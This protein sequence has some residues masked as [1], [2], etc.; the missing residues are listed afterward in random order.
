MRFCVKNKFSRNE[1]VLLISRNERV[2]A[3]FIN[4]CLG[5]QI[6]S[7]VKAWRLEKCARCH[8]CDGPPELWVVSAIKVPR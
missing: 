8:G 2:F 1:R 4:F 5:I 3:N 7:A 6:L